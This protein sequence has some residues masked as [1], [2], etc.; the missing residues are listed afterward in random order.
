MNKV[1]LTI[2]AFLSSGVSYATDIPPRCNGKEISEAPEFLTGLSIPE[3]LYEITTETDGEIF[4]ITVEAPSE[5]K[6][7]PINQINLKR[8]VSGKPVLAAGLAYIVTEGTAISTT[9]LAWP[10]EIESIGFN[11]HYAV[12]QQCSEGH[13][14]LKG[15]SAYDLVYKHNKAVNERLRLD[16]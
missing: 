13:S 12:Y 9:V 2:L 15:S 16:R 10:S 11:L 8:M 4:Y 6:G 7:N 14:Y 5:Y 3:N 1:F